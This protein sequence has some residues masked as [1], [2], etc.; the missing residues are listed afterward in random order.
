MRPQLHW[1]RRI[2][3]MPCMR[4][5]RVTQ[6]EMRPIQSDIEY[7]LDQL[8]CRLEALH[9]ERDGLL[10][11]IHDV[12]GQIAVWQE[13]WKLEIPEEERRHANVPRADSAIV[14]MSLSDAVDHLRR[15][16]PGITK[17]LARIHLETI[18]YDFKGK[19]PGSAV[20]FAWVN[21]DR[22]KRKGNRQDSNG[23]EPE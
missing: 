18:G 12:E 20:H 8:K 11:Q 7:R 9:A 23:M 22:R 16:N 17:E 2:A 1:L 5:A 10:A 6:L 13:A 21:V 15:Q 19:K 4:G 3:I 14:R